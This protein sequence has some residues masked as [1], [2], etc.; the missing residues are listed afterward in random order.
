MKKT[1]A[2]AAVAGSVIL[3]AATIDL[4]QLDNYAGQTRPAYIQK[5]NTPGNN[6]LTDK[7]ATL[8]RVLFYDKN[9]SADNSI[10]CGSC[11]QQRFAFGDTA[12]R[13]NGINGGLTGRHTMR[14]VN[15][16]FGNEVKFFWDERAAS[17]EAQTTQPIQNHVEMGFS[18]TNGDLDLDSLIRK[19][20]TISYYETLFTF[21]YGDADITE[22][23]IQQALAQFVR[24]IQSFDAKYDIGRAQVPN[25]AAPFPN[26]TQQENMGKNLFLAPPPNGAGCQGCHRA[27][28]F[29]IDPNSLNNNVIGVFDAPGQTDL[30]NTRAPSLRDLVNPDGTLNGPLMHDG[31]ISTLAALIDHYD[32]IVLNPANTNLDPRLV[33]PGGQGQ[34]LQLNQT[35]KDALIAF[36]KTLTGSNLYTDPK[37]SDPFDENGNLTLVPATA[38]VNESME[39]NI[40]LFPNPTAGWIT[41]DVPAGTYRL[42]V[43]DA[44]GRRLG[45][46]TVYPQ[47]TLDLS[48]LPDGLLVFRITDAGTGETFVKK[49]IKNHP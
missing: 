21:V 5:D 28:E 9:L 19:L 29:D 38:S 43:Y 32:H 7:G 17:L 31:S 49:I 37:W 12:L 22:T 15:A 35:Q 13:S 26:F 4:N 48:A 33:G 39:V 41:V 42:E 8:G 2:L 47:Q 25:D 11:H 1:I 10:A 40:R 6:L 27:P 3:M 30:T 18:G 45:A 34:N 16:R 14:L 20:E 46:Q 44:A 23:R 36:L 24:S